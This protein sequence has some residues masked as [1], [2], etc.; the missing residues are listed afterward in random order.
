MFVGILGL[1]EILVV[2]FYQ[3]VMHEI[4]RAHR[5]NGKMHSS[6]L[7]TQTSTHI[8]VHSNAISHSDMFNDRSF[9]FILFIREG[10]VVANDKSLIEH[11]HTMRVLNVAY[12]WTEW[13]ASCNIYFTQFTITRSSHIRLASIT[14]NFKSCI[15]SILHSHS[16]HILTSLCVSFLL[17]K[18]RN[19]VFQSTKHVTL[20]SMWIFLPYTEHEYIQFGTMSSLF[21]NTYHFFFFRIRTTSI[22]FDCSIQNRLKMIQNEMHRVHMSFSLHAWTEPNWNNT[23]TRYTRTGDEEHMIRD[24]SVSIVLFTLFSFFFSNVSEV[25]PHNYDSLRFTQN[26]VWVC[27]FFFLCRFFERKSYECTLKWSNACMCARD[28]RVVHVTR[29]WRLSFHRVGCTNFP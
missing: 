7:C 29:C 22:L 6:Q 23:L 13:V 25:Q 14:Y 16:L 8:R 1:N 19:D 21:L 10:S 2:R 28:D 11:R 17:S 18:I 12:M 3:F 24:D 15:F 26:C 4:T 27:G 9:S 5:I 20:W